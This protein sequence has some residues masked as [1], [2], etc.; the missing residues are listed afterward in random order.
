MIDMKT[1]IAGIELKNPIVLASGTSGYGFELNDFFDVSDF[2]A[3]TLKAL[4]INPRVGNKPERI[5]ELKNAM[6]NAI[7]LA[8]KGIKHFEESI[9]PKL[10]NI[11]TNIIANIAGGDIDEYANICDI[12]NKQEKISMYELNV[13]CPNVHSNGVVFANDPDALYKLIEKC[14][15]ISAKPLIVKLPP[16]IFAIEKIVNIC[17][18]AGASAISLIN[19]VPA[20]DINIYK[21][22][23]ILANNFGGLSGEAIKPIALRLV[24]LARKATTLPI[25]GGGGVNNAEDVVKFLMAG[26]NAV[27][28]GT[29]T[30]KD[31]NASYKLI[32]ELAILI[33]KLKANSVTEII[34]S[35]EL[36]Q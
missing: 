9:I 16:D 29:L 8:N 1:K 12:L 19:T 24:Y 36:N 22:K 14:S 33:E 6:I 25:I 15:K 7:G 26:A 18:S 3:I 23:P 13:S 31:P 2:G 28:V 35:L 21:K 5:T 11:D 27:S 17:E 10:K 34:G 20:M 30:L 32:N 4:T